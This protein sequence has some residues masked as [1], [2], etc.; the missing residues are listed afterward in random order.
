MKSAF[1]CFQESARCELK[2][3]IAP[4]EGARLFLLDAARDWKRCGEEAGKEG[5]ASHPAIVPA[6]NR[7]VPYD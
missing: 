4:T 3:G 6:T 1:E 5:T 7:V 2:A